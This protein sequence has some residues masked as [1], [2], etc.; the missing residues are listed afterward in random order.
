MN[1]IV[2]NNFGR[3]CGDGPV[4]NQP[5]RRNDDDLSDVFGAL[6]RE[7]QRPAAPE[8]PRPVPQR[9]PVRPPAPR[10]SA[11]PTVRVVTVLLVINVLMFAVTAVLSGSVDPSTGA[12]YVLGA[13]ENSAIDGGAWW[14]LLTPMVLHGSVL[15]LL[16][17]SWALYALGPAVEAAYGARRFLAIYL[18]AGLAGSMAS[19]LFNPDALSVGASGAIFGLLGALAARIFSAR[20]VLGRD[21]TKMQFGQIGSMIAINLL[22][23]FTVQGI[24]NAAHIGGLV[25]GGLVGLVLAPQYRRVHTHELGAPPRSANDRTAWV[26]VAMIAVVLVAGFLALRTFV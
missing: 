1:S 26:Q 17:N 21:A 7:F 23:G 5:P 18:L 16:F 15:H 19:Y 24:D 4:S 3:S 2:A 25:L 9:V 14:R 20:S 13:K 11:L 8:R 22:F 10:R 6:E 12:L